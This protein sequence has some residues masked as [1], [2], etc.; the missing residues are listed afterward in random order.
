MLAPGVLDEIAAKYGLPASHSITRLGNGR[1]NVTYGAKFGDEPLVV[2]QARARWGLARLASEHEFMQYLSSEGLCVP[3]PLTSKEGATFVV[4][5]GRAFAVYRWGR[6]ERFERGNLSHARSGG[7]ALARYHHL[8]ARY[9]RTVVS[10]EDDF[11]KGFLAAAA[12]TQAGSEQLVEAPDPE[13]VGMCG[14]LR[15]RLAPLVGRMQ[16]LD[17]EALPALTIHGDYRRANLLVGGDEVSA[18]LDFDRCRLEARVLDVA[19]GVSSLARGTD[20]R[21]FLDTDLARAFVS[22]YI[23]EGGLNEKELEALPILVEARVAL[24]AMTR[25]ERFADVD[26]AELQKRKRKLAKYTDRLRWL[27]TNDEWRK[28]VRGE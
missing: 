25:A 13:L 27:E 2:R 5:D 6:G 4:V 8:A 23:E 12:R 24:S 9:P 7:R 11:R 14:Y 16:G 3:A 20:K 19:M 1:E 10:A 22:A 18:V 21:E 26:P 17:Y 15:A 28:A